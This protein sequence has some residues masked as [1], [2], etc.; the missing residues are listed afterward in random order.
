MFKAQNNTGSPQQ[1]N[2]DKIADSAELKATKLKTS[3]NMR[4]ITKNYEPF[5]AA[6]EPKTVLVIPPDKIKFDKGRVIHYTQLKPQSFTFATAED[7]K[8]DNRQQ[9]QQQKLNSLYS[10]VNNL[11]DVFIKNS[12]ATNNEYTPCRNLNHKTSSERVS[13][14]KRTDRILS[15]SVANNFAASPRYDKVL[16]KGLGPEFLQPSIVGK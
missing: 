1:L 10:T 16:D 14:L 2:N 4:V 6:N 9:H 7:S 12:K 5:Q 8:S 11:Q 15:S 13:K 3:I